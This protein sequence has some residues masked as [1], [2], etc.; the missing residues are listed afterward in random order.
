MKGRCVFPGSFDPPTR[1]HIDLIRRA[2]RIFP[3]VSAV[4][5]RNPAKEGCFSPEER[6]ELLRKACAGI[7]NVRVEAFDGLLVDYARRTEADVVVRGLRSAGDFEN[8]F[9][10]AQANRSLAPQVE[11]LFLPTSPEHSYVSSSMAREVAR[12][13]GDFA[14]LIPPEILPEVQE[15]LGRKRG[16]E[17]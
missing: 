11:T 13:G 8:E 4:V 2:A 1:G 5:L 15:R 12:F 10:M 14:A 7:P 3:E 9:Y 6:V 16:E 17:T